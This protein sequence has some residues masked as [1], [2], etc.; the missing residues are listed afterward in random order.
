MKLKNHKSILAH[1]KY[2]EWNTADALD[3]LVA[4]EDIASSLFAGLRLKSKF[5]LIFFQYVIVGSEKNRNQNIKSIFL[6]Y[7]L[8]WRFYASSRFSLSSLFPIGKYLK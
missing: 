8:A 7:S 2:L 1:S 3:E 6:L 4:S 5:F